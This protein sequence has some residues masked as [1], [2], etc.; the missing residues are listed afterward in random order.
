MICD[1]NDLGY[2]DNF[3]MLGGNVDDF[4]SLGYFSG[5]NASLDPYYMYL[6]DKPRNHVKFFL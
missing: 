1:A 4:I 3:S 5:Y 2:E 6:V